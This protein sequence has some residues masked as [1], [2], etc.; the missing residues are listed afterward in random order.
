MSGVDANALQMSFGT[1]LI[2]VVVYL[3]LENMLIQVSPVSGMIADSGDAG[4]VLS[5]VLFALGAY[6]TATGLVDAMDS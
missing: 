4:A 6:V 3:S 1:T 5:V 2:A